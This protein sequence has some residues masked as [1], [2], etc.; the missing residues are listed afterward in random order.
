MDRKRY[1]Q[2]ILLENVVNLIREHRLIELQEVMEEYHTIDVLDILDNLEDNMKITLFEVL[3]ANTAASIIEESEVAFF[4]NIFLNLD[5]ES[6][7]NILELVSLGDMADILNDLDEEKVNDVIKLLSREDANELKAMQVYEEESTGG[8]MSNKYIEIKKNMTAKEAIQHMR[9]NASDAETIYYVYVIDEDDKLVGVLSLRELILAREKSIIE[10]L[11]TENIKF[12]YDYE[13]REEAVK[14]VSKYNL[15]AIPVVDKDKILKGIITVDDIID[16]MEEEATEDM[17]RFAGTSEQERDIAIK[18]NN[19]AYDQVTSSVMARIPWLI[20]MLALG[21]LS[22][23]VFKKLG[24][25]IKDEYTPL[26]IFIPLIMSM[27]GT[28]A[29]QSSA[30]TVMSLSNKDIEFNKVLREVLVGIIIGTICSLIVAILIIILK[31]EFDI[32]VIVSLSLIIN[33]IIGSF[34]GGFIPV[35]LKNINKDP[36]MI[37]APL[38]SVILDITG[39]GVYYII[40]NIVM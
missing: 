30:F 10:D 32:L 36:S 17:Y 4:E 15:V 1:D 38:M 40:T 18:A 2:E 16:V 33:M 35:F 11:M 22:A 13:D 25:M 34:I 24:F 21:L 39:L 27:G 5:E 3:P 20:L 12:V 7:K 37:S 9:D 29:T 19:S 26:I 8:I 6:K 23:L 28:I 31:I 14:V